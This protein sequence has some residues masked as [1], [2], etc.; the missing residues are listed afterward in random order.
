M[1]S[2]DPIRGDERMYGAAL[3]IPPIAV[4]GESVSIR[5][6]MVTALVVV[7]ASLLATSATC[8][9]ELTVQMARIFVA[10]GLRR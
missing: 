2:V 1:H 4:A 6:G 9:S 7:F 8:R 10:V 5:I 3:S